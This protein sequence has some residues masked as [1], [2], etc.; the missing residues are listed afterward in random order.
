ME[1]CMP[2]TES[3]YDADSNESTRFQPLMIA[4]SGGSGHKSA[5][6]GIISFLQKEY[7]KVIILPQYHP[8]EHKVLSRSEDRG[9]QG[10]IEAGLKW[11]HEMG[12]LSDILRGIA[13]HSFF[14]VLP[15]R[16]ELVTEIEM[17][18]KQNPPSSTRLYVDMLLDVLTAG[19]ESAA[20]ANILARKDEV[21]TLKKLLT[22]QPRSDALNYQL[23]YEYYLNLLMKAY[24]TKEPYT[25]VISTQVVAL[26]ALC[27]AVIEYN[28]RVS[29]IDSKL[30]ITIHQYMTDLPTEG[31][32]HYFRPLNTL[33]ESQRRQLKFYAVNLTQ[34][35]I[36]RFIDAQEEYQGLFCIPYDKNP[37]VRCG[38]LDLETSLHNKWSIENTVSYIDYEYSE[39]HGA[40]K[41][42]KLISLTIKPNDRV[43][44]IM[45]GS[46]ASD[47]TVD[48]LIAL[49]KAGFELI[50]I[51]GGLNHNIYSAI[52]RIKY[53]ENLGPQKQLKN[54]II[55]L[56]HQT[57]KEIQPI[58]SRSSV[59]Y[60]R[61][62]GL[63]TFEQMAMP[64][65]SKQSIFLHHAMPEEIPRRCGINYDAI[66]LKEMRRLVEEFQ[67]FLGIELSFFDAASRT[68]IP[69]ST[70][71]N[72]LTSGL[73]WED[74]NVGVLINFLSQK[75]HIHIK[76][77]TK[78]LASRH[79]SE[80]TQI[81]SLKATVNPTYFPLISDAPEKMRA[82][83]VDVAAH[84]KALVNFY[85]LN[86][87]SFKQGRPVP[88]H[89]L[90]TIILYIQPDLLSEENVQILIEHP[91]ALKSA[92]VL[93]SV[94]NM[95]QTMLD[96]LVEHSSVCHAL[97]NENIASTI[98]YYW[99]C[100]KSNTSFNFKSL[101]HSWIL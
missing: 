1:R 35:C 100:S 6:E 3:L 27:D 42:S 9:S 34:A 33:S 48:Y 30:Q 41:Q 18:I 68:H 8:T 13:K 45:L 67:S 85:F 5:I 87:D 70:F 93:L 63:S 89:Q 31:A 55:R 78:S 80:A 91:I 82:K 25:S 40:M 50:F 47:D 56:G 24:K 86:L 19:Y 96:Y 26:P 17:L 64:H 28:K 72:E 15:T 36:D 38:F 77:T 98:F 69:S 74:G 4:S 65:N 52:E 73:A 16:V 20:I 2:V 71:V 44:S 83:V 90:E 97:L 79:L 58:F 61:G 54:R 49:L 62:G 21:K 37:M 84:S 59:I 10:Q 92:S 7:E 12:V 29:Q 76:R 101:S 95:M 99:V 11:L 14:P 57:D 75:S 60:I 32:Q 43:A 46:Q 88:L 53:E 23:V 94:G 66:Q 81:A 22:F 51:F 39:T